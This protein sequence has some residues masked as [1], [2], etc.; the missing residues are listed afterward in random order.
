MISVARLNL[1]WQQKTKQ[2]P[3]LPVSCG[4]CLPSLNLKVQKTK[5]QATNWES[6]LCRFFEFHDCPLAAAGSFTVDPVSGV[7]KTSIKHYNPG[8]TYR[9]FAQARDRTPTDL[10]VSQVSLAEL[11]TSV[12]VRL[13]LLKLITFT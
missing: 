8:Q 10:Q 6:E 13:V 11:I 9:I 3:S 1:E 5:F 7:V 2:P 4:W 12:E